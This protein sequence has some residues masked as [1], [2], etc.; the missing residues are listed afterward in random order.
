MY[1]QL[2]G[3]VTVKSVGATQTALVPA[4]NSPARHPANAGQNGSKKSN[5]RVFAQSH[6][7]RRL[8]STSEYPWVANRRNKDFFSPFL[9]AFIDNQP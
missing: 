4:A 2:M 7:S 6:A 5:C 9:F 3:E 1:V 8:Q